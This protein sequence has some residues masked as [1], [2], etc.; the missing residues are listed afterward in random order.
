MLFKTTALIGLAAFSLCL[1]DIGG[2]VT[3]TSGKIPIPG[4][5]VK[6]ERGGQTAITGADGQFTLGINTSISVDP[7]ERHVSSQPIVRIKNG[8]LRIYVAARTA[9]ETTTFDLAG[10]EL[11]TVRQTMDAGTHGI[12]LPR[13]GAGVFLY[14]VKFGAN[15]VILSGQSIGDASPGRAGSIHA[16]ASQNTMARKMKA[17]AK[18]DDIMVVTK[19][20]YLKYRVVVRN[21]DT[22][23]LSIRMIVCADSVTDADGNVYHAVRLGNQVWTV[24]NLRTSKYHDGTPVTR[25]TSILTWTDATT[26]K[27]CYYN[28]SENADSV[29]K[30]GALYN[31]YVVSPA[32]PKKI[33]PDG[34]HVPADSEW[35]SLEAY[36]VAQGYSS[37]GNIAHYFITNSLQTKTDWHVSGTL[38]TIN[39]A[40][41]NNNRS[42]FSALPGGERMGGDSSYVGPGVFFGQG[43][44]GYWWTATEI[45]GARAGSRALYAGFKILYSPDVRKDY[46]FSVRLVRD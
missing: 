22:S 33:A 40:L 44:E 28:N 24:E 17:D 25:D 4:A 5:V 30:Y 6:C 41:A 18:I 2:I 23:G 43:C 32:N 35:T 1:A 9:L 15:E 31:W 26:E 3:D 37:D 29:K 46:G 11:G 8:V 16:A 27:F 39:N 14:K 34:W 45:D 42:G 7:S 12:A 36:L 20:G 13:A 19:A 38:G 10:K 21:S